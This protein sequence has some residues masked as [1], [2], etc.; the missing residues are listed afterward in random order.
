MSLCVCTMASDL[1]VV[2]V[3]GNHVGTFEFTD[4]FQKRHR[5]SEKEFIKE[6]YQ[7]KS[8]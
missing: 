1:G 4:P 6:K 3:T 8:S 5:F 7:K 2:G